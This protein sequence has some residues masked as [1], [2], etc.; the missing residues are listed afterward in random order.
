MYIGMMVGLFGYVVERWWGT[1]WVSCRMMVVGDCL[2][3][4]LADGEGLFVCDVR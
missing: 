4:L 3:V 2:G 1:V